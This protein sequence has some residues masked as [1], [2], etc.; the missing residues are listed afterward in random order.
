MTRAAARNAAV[1]LLGL[2]VLGVVL[3]NATNVDAQPPR[4]A[5]YALTHHLAADDDVALTNSAV[6]VTF[7][8]TVDRGT[9]EA[10]FTMTPLVDGTF[11]W[12]GTTM[13][14]TPAG[15][16]PIDGEFTVRVDEGV[17]DMAGNRSGAPSEPFT[18]R[19]VGRPAI[20]ASE[21]A[22]GGELV[23]ESPITLTFSTLMDTASVDRALRVRPAFA[24]ATRWSGEAV[25]IVPATALR[26]AT[27]Y[28][29]VVDRRAT[30][31]AGNRLLRPFVLHFSTAADVL[32]ARWVAPADGLQG[33]SPYT[34]IAVAFD[35]PLQADGLDDAFT[36]QPDVPGSFSVEPLAP[37]GSGDGATVLRFQPSSSLPAN[38]TFAV[39]IA[40]GVAS[41]D[42]A[43]LDEPLS[44]TFTTGA[45]FPSLQN[46]VLFLSDRTGIRNLWAMNVDGSNQRQ[47]STELVAVLEYDVSLDGRRF[48]VGDGAR[49]VEYAADGG[50]RTPLTGTDVLEFDAS[51]RPDGEA[52]IFSRADPA[53][54]SGLG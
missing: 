21:P 29:L 23:G 11:T 2:A 22:E 50:D 28:E 48:V 31:L 43:L 19:T 8:E 30:D 17:R 44:W 35:H 13:A 25:Q 34:P 39:E 10:A 51:Y 46:Q 1:L 32:E 47:L 20:A 9:A 52:L 5:S 54:G 38:T 24:Y 45:P 7:S 18:F 37:D 15:G 36:I 42:G 40:A 33:V 14:F 4:V 16:L 41:S 26:S 53:T 27:T 49:L 3:V 12:A 6:E